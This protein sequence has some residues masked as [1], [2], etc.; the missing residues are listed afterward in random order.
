M[1]ASGGY[2]IACAASEIIVA[3]NALVGSLGVRFSGFGLNKLIERLGIDRRVYTKGESKAML[4][5]FLSEKQSDIDMIM[6]VQDDI[7]QN[8]KSQVHKGRS[9]KLKIPD[10]QLFSGAIWSGKQAIEIGLADKIGDLYSEMQ[11]RF[12]IDVQINII[13]QEKSWLK[14]KL[15]IMIESLSQVISDNILNLATKKIEL[16]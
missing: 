4:D 15:G 5:P 2:W 1:A 7:Y 12:G 10:D 13:N 3:E 6:K 8:F 9:E 16:R 11:D 14:R